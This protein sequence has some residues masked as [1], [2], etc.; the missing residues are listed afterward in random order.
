MKTLSTHQV[1]QISESS[2]S[3]IWN[4]KRRYR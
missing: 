1:G 3:T 4:T 2:K